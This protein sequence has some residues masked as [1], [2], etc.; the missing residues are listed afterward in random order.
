MK[1]FTLSSSCALFVFVLGWVVCLLGFF[2][3]MVNKRWKGVIFRINFFSFIRRVLF[4]SVNSVM[5]V[6]N[7]CAMHQNK[8]W[9]KKRQLILKI[10]HTCFAFFF[11]FPF[12]KIRFDFIKIL[13][14]DKNVL[15]TFVRI[16]ALFQRKYFFPLLK[17]NVI[18]SKG[19]KENTCLALK[20][21]VF[22]ISLPF[23]ICKSIKSK[24]CYTIWNKAK[25]LND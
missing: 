19:K 5:R 22:G 12:P 24:S 15:D 13:W 20:R 3:L 9:K 2:F 11:D 14:F 8:D 7:Y 23:H 1:L 16:P 6:R 18:L 25:S 4:Y 21:I 10:T 17:S